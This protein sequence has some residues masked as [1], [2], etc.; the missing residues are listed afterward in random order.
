MDWLYLL[1]IAVFTLLNFGLIRLADT[2]MKES[3]E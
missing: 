2:L 1:E 3:R